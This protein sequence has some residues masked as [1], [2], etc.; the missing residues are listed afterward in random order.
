MTQVERWRAEF[1]QRV[2]EAIK[3]RRDGRM[4]GAELADATA[5]LGYPLTRSQIANYESGRKQ[6]LD[7]IELWVIAT[8]LGVA[9]L[10]L[11]L[12]GRPDQS[13]EM[14]PGGQ[15]ATTLAAA[16]WFVGKPA[17]LEDLTGAV[18][19]LTRAIAPAGIGTAEQFGPV[20]VT[21]EAP[22]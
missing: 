2:A 21:Q 17:W 12:P 18:D 11:L 20:T 6:S 9:P 3:R 7:V 19:Q 22:R 14:L 5:R 8:A 13:V 4:S 16:T 1:H 15:T 10:E